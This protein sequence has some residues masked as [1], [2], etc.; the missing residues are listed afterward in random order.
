MHNFFKQGWSFST[1]QWSPGS[2]YP[3]DHFRA[4]LRD[5]GRPGEDIKTMWPSFKVQGCLPLSPCVL[6]H[7]I[8]KLWGSR[9]EHPMTEGQKLAKG[10]HTG[11]PFLLSEFGW[12]QVKHMA[13]FYLLCRAEFENKILCLVSFH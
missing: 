8:S 11:K 7:G 2:Y 1:S 6:Y 3:R 4:K 10:G 5:Q 12:S 13:F 9:S